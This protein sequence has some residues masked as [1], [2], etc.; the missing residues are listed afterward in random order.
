[1]VVMD[2]D[3][4]LDENALVRG[5]EPLKVRKIGAV[6]ADVRILTR[7]GGILQ[8]RTGSGRDRCHAE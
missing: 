4:V 8:D 6:S 7:I 5:V 1:M 3:T 2:S